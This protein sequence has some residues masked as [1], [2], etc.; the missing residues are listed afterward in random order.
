MTEELVLWFLTT[1]IGIGLFLILVSSLSMILVIL[2]EFWATKGHRHAGLLD[3]Q[4]PRER[5]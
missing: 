1:P 2:I 4:R 3:V 5:E